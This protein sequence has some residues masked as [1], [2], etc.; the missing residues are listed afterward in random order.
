MTSFRVKSPVRIDLCGGTLDLWPIYCNLGSGRTINC[1]IS[2]FASVDFEVEDAPVFRCE[3]KNLSGESYQF[4]K[5]LAQPALAGVP[6]GVR[7]PVFVISEYL[8]RREDLPHQNWKVTLSADFPLRSG[9]GG[10]SALAVALARGIARIY[11]DFSEQGWQWTMMNWVRDI[12][13]AYLRVPTGT[14]DYLASLFGGL[15]SFVSSYGGIERVPFPEDVASSLGERL[16]VLFSGE[17]HHSGISNWELFKRA[18]DGDKPMWD[19]LQ[20]IAQLS[21]QLDGEL[22]GHVNWKYVGQ[23][24]SE[25][26]K[27][28]R[29]I[30][31]VQTSRLDEIFDFLKNKK[32]LGAKVCGAAQGG[33]LVV[34]VDPA[35]KEKLIGEC[36]AHK[37]QVLQA[38]PH[39]SPVAILPL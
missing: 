39:N 15:N 20:T 16:V 25:E 27:V 26:W 12:E 2:L 37:I 18:F 34:L 13:A 5:P 38:K 31:K 30:F 8:K 11:S 9:L 17:M 10:S 33:S 3:L 24:L 22:R 14:Q 28:R 32:V 23:I 1:A 6:Q 29:D 7:F 36:E 4:T 19:G 21:E 35:H